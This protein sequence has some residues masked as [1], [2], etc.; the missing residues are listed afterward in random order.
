MFTGIVETL[1]TISRVTTGD[2][3]VT[4]EISAPTLDD[5]KVGDS[6]STS[7]V[8]L[9]VTTLTASGFTTDIM[10]ETLAVTTLGSM[11]TGDQV[12]LERAMALGDRLGGHIVQGHVD[13]IGAVLAVTPHDKWRVIRFSLPAQIAALVIYKGSITIN[14]VA[15]TISALGSDWFEVSLIPETLAVTTLGSLT[16]GDKVNLESDMVARHI[17]RLNAV[18]TLGSK[19][20][21]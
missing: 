10:G 4:W 12:N 19:E 8:C 9:T 1:G 20:N 7:G 18:A 11:V 3:L 2:D 17:A 16:I 6:V 13:A 14:G 5:L 21:L 15:L